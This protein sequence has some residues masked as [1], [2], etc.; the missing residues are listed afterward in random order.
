M[1]NVTNKG[2]V[3]DL[4]TGREVAKFDMNM[5][6]LTDYE[7]FSYDGKGVV[8]PVADKGGNTL[9]YQPIDGAA[10]HTLL[11]PV[12]EAIHDFAWSPS[13]KQLAVARLQ[14]SSDV[15]LITDEGSKK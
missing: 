12:P 1:E 6:I 4:A 11:D 9:L 15:V 10:P 8:Y 5:S 14:S 13:G 3:T 2:V 7:H